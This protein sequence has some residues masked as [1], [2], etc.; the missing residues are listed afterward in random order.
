MANQCDECGFD[1]ETPLIEEIRVIGR[2]PDRVSRLAEGA[3]DKLYERPAPETWSPNEYVWHL[4]DS[5]RVFAE[6][7]HMTR[8]LDH[9][10]HTTFDAD[11][12]AELRSYADRPAETGIW[13]LHHAIALFIQEAAIA[14]PERQ[15]TY[16]GWREDVTAGEVIGFA[17]HEVVHHTLDLARA[18]GKGTLN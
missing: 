18:L 12:M 3:G 17:A 5:F 2:F 16:K 11:Q 6:W 14:E 8:T 10:I 7:L 1:W 4:V 13:A 15:V 9:P